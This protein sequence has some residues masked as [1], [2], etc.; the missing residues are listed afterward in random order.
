MQ[1]V[2]GIALQHHHV[3]EVENEIRPFVEG[4]QDGKRAF[5]FES[6]AAGIHISGCGRLG[7]IA[8]MQDFLR[9]HAA[10][11]GDRTL[12]AAID[13]AV[14]DAG[15]DADHQRDLVIATGD[16]LGSVAHVVSPAELLEADEICMLGAQRKEQVG[17]GGETIIGAVVD[18]GR[19][20]GRRRQDRLE[21]VF[22]GCEDRAARQHARDDH[23]PLGAD[24]RRMRRVSDRRGRVD[25]ACADDD[26][27]A[28]AHETLHTFHPLRIGQ[29]RPVTHGS[30][31]DHCRHSRGDQLLGLA[32]ERV[33]VGAAILLARGHEGRDDAGKDAAIHVDFLR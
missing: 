26:R 14:E 4:R 1:G 8:E 30:A 9:Q 10:Y 5:E 18:H 3:L 33:E 17:P 12:R 23:E 22:L 21:M 32:H 27:N 28:R 31:I 15:V 11:A 24:F 20:I 6:R 29:K 25:R 19:K 2:F 16:V 7:E 13:V